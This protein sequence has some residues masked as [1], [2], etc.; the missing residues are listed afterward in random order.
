MNRPF[1]SLSR[2]RGD[3]QREDWE[4]NNNFD[5]VTFLIERYWLEIYACTSRYTMFWKHDQTLNAYDKK[6][7]RNK[8]K[9]GKKW[10]KWE[11]LS[12]TTGSPNVSDFK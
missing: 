6:L 1:V 2:I 4:D 5:R 10:T 11:D 12:V 3:R 9:L 8:W 7:N